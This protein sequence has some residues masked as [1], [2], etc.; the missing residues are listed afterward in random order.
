MLHE[1]VSAN[2]GNLLNSY[3]NERSHR[4]DE[5]INNILY[6]SKYFYTYAKSKS[7][8]KPRVG[9]LKYE[10]SMYSKNYDMAKILNSQYKRVFSSSKYTPKEVEI[11]NETGVPPIGGVFP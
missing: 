8:I 10:G 11:I 7:T 6:N 2:E 3:K 4:E 9:P 1:T 5:A